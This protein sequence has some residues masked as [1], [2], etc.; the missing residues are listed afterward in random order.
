M[1]IV[2][3]SESFPPRVGG[4]EKHLFHVS[5]ELTTRGHAVT[6]LTPHRLPGSAVQER[7]RDVR[8]FRFPFGVNSPAARKVRV[9]LWLLRRLPL[10]AGCDVVHIHD[11]TSLLAWYLP[12]R[13]LLPRKPVFI[14]FHGHSGE[15]PLGRRHLWERRAAEKL[16]RGNICVGHYLER[17]YGTRAGPITYGGTDLPTGRQ[18]RPHLGNLTLVF[19]GRLEPDTGVILYLRAVALLR[20]RTGRSWKLIICGDGSLRHRVQA[21]IRELDLDAELAGAV[22]DPLPWV[23]KSRFVFTSGYLALLEAWACR[24]LAFAVYENPLKRDY[25]E[26][27][28]GARQMMVICGSAEELKESVLR[29]LGDPGREAS[30]VDTAHRFA[31][32]QTWARVAETYW[33]LYE[34]HNLR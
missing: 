33:Q 3:L 32:E 18:T 9:R 10:L 23:R 13:F 19:V 1:H 6:I 31:S 8:V 20:E 30:L 17:W 12:F 22:P 29:V 7:L 24:R 4:V 28:P 25:L 21:L 26:M 15:F 14:T 2:M 27:M 5:Q 11:Q 16:T 34:S